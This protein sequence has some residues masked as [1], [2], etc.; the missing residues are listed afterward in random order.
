MFDEPTVP[1]RTYS[2]PT[3]PT[4]TTRLARERGTTSP[5]AGVRTI[6]REEFE[7]KCW[8]AP[9]MT[10]PIACF[11][12]VDGAAIGLVSRDHMTTSFSIV[13][14]LVGADGFVLDERIDGIS[15]RWLAIADLFDHL[16]SGEET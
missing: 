12:R 11:E 2:R 7:S 16:G 3:A 1:D 6:S 14:F 4:R 5:P 10:T 13:T 9:P 15:E 8:Y